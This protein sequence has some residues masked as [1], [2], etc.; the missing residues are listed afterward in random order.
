MQVRR[1]EI[2]VTLCALLAWSAL[3]LAGD[4]SA[5]RA[6][7]SQD[8]P[9]AGAA[10]SAD[11]REQLIQGLEAELAEDPKNAELHYKLGNAN[12]DA[13][14]NRVALDHFDEALSLDSSMSRAWVNK[15]V[16]LKELNRHE[17][18]IAA[19][20][21]ALELDPEDPLAHVNLGDEYLLQK[22]Y[23]EAVDAYRQALKID[24][25]CAPA[26]YSLAI[27]FAETGMYRD[28]ART[29]KKCAEVAEASQGADSDTYKRATENAKL[30]EQIVADAEEQLK[31][32]Q[33]LAD[34]LKAKED[35]E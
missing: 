22:R 25:K 7:A 23:G 31:E 24:P 11:P 4:E 5:T 21:K 20:E 32:R 13:G 27:S 1:F 8:A 15:G 3:A 26:Y 10:R 2:A 30:M 12:L 19:F 28:A 33:D 35:A 6:E 34:E 29:W 9:P 16:V 14:Y 18:A 17:E